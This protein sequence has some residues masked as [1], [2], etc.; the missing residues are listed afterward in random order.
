MT[1]LGGDEMDLRQ[2]TEPLLGAGVPD[3]VVDGIKPRPVQE[4]TK[5]QDTVRWWVGTLQ[6]QGDK[7]ERFCVI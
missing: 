5:H 6:N 2:A 3:G 7:R 4:Q 1:Y